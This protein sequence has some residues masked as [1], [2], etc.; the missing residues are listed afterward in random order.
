MSS[1]S[2][3]PISWVHACISR[4]RSSQLPL[5]S[6]LDKMQILACTIFGA[7]AGAILL[8]IA[9]SA[10]WIVT[11]PMS[12]WISGKSVLGGFLGGTLGTEAGKKSV[13]WTR[14]T[15]DSW[16]PA[17]VVGLVVGRMACQLS[18]TWD[19][20]YGSPTGLSIGWDY[21]DGLPRYPTALI[22]LIGVVAVW[23]ALRRRA[24]NRPGQSF[25]AF[26][27]GYCVLRFFIEF[28][29]PPFGAAAPGSPPVELFAGLTAIQ[30]TALAGTCWM[31]WRL[32][33]PSTSA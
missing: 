13:G 4:Q 18:G 27:L 20:T 15:G 19:M 21:G 6:A 30:W 24:W 17:L 12:A 11:Q 14:S 9:E 26:L 28:L 22:E 7:A 31:A 23:L 32:R 29:K 25:N 33:R 3:S 1:S 10:S 5:P 2:G 8:H 16:V